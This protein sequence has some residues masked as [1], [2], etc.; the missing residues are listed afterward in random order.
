MVTKNKPQ[1]CARHKE[2]S[3]APRP[4]ALLDRLRFRADG[5]MLAGQSW[6]S[7]TTLLH[8]IG[9]ELD[10]ITSGIVH[11]RAALAFGAFLGGAAVAVFNSQILQV[12]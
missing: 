10:D 9:N 8:A 1:P 11:I 3:A 5:C 2:T 7:A 4:I 12:R 6:V